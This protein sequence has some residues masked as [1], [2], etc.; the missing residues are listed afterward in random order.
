MRFDTTRSLIAIAFA[1]ACASPTAL[2]SISGP[3]VFGTD[4]R[5]AKTAPEYRPHAGVGCEL[6]SAA[7]TLDRAIELALCRNPATRA[8]WAAAQVQAAALGVAEGAYLPSIAVTG[9]ENHLSGDLTAGALTSTQQDG[10]SAVAA[11]SWTLVDFGAR[12]SDVANARSL[13][14]AAAHTGSATAQR[15]VADVIQSYYGV[16]ATDLAVSANQQTEANAA[17]SL[18]VAR[19]LQTGG[20]ATL[21]DVMQAET[22]YQQSVY[23]RIQ[24][25]NAAKAS[26]ANL[27]TL[28]GFSADQP[29]SLA[30]IAAPSAPAVTARVGELLT[31]AAQ[32][33]PDLAAAR[34]QRAAAEAEVTAARAVGRPKISFGAQRSVSELTAYPR[35][36]TNAV[37]FSVSVPVFSGLQTHYGIRR[38]QAALDEVTAQVEQ[39]R[40]SVSLDV[41]NAYHSLDAANQ[42]LAT[43]A[44]LAKAAATNEE[45]AIGRYQSGVG[46]IL[47]VLTAQSAGSTARLVRIQAEYNWQSARAQLALAVGRLSSNADLE[48]IAPTSTP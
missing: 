38:A 8:A 12:R 43:S 28:L 44:A 23:N 27:A 1:A 25:V 48:A 19:A 45:I 10:K 15:T 42:A 14:D 24:A 9:N 2:A 41:W 18:E 37:G 7:L 21:A 3:D 32:Q 6:P 40:L 5:I 46:S 4:S 47:D 30:P 33:R 26:R 29:L 17:R 31:L 36:N 13:L 11:L 20:A 34:D 16:V 22:A 39:S 35:Q